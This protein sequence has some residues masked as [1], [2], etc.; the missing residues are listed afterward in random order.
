MRPLTKKLI[1]DLLRLWPQVTAI[2]L[3]M[4]AGVATLILAAGAYASLHETRAAYYQRNRFG[5]IFASVTRA[6]KRLV[7]QIE[8]IPGV[9]TVDSRIVKLALLDIVGMREPA[10]ARLISLPD[11]GQQVLNRV[12]LRA[13]RFPLAGA[14]D[15][16]VVNESFARAHGFGIGSRFAVL[17][18]GAKRRLRIVGIGL[19]PEYIY[20]LGPGELMPDDRRFGVVFLSESVLAA[21]YDLNGAFSDVSV[22]LL[23]DASRA[24]VIEALDR[25]LKPHGGQGA[26]SRKDQLSHAFIDSELKQ[27]QAMARVLPPIFLLVATFLVNMTLS[28]L[29]A[30]ERAEIGLLKAIGYS[31]VAVGAHYLKFVLAIAFFGIVIGAVAGTLLGI[32]L[33]RLYADFFRFPFLIF[34]K[35][36][37][38]YV[39]AAAITFAASFLGALKAVSEVVDLP[40]AVAMAPP[41]PPRYRR[42]FGAGLFRRLALSRIAMMAFRHVAHRPGRTASSVFGISLSVAILV[43]SLWMIPSIE[44]MIDVTFFQTERQDVSI[45]FAEKRRLAALFEARRLPGVL[46]A[47]PYRRVPVRIRKGHVERRIAI[48]GKPETVDLNRVLNAAFQ[49]I[50]PPARGLAV[51]DML[52]DV[53]KVERGDWVE[54]DVLE[55]RR[56]T[57]RITVAEIVTGFLGIS[58]FIELSALNRLLREGAM[59]SGVHIVYDRA[60]ENAFFAAVKDNPATGFV[61]LQKSSLRQFRK[62]LAE[63]INIMITVYLAFAVIIAFGVVYN[64]AR[65]SL[66]E[67]GRELA[68]LRVLGFTKAEVSRVLLIELAFTTLAAQPF[69]WVIGHGLAYAT[70][71]GFE[72]E[73]YRIPFVIGPPVYAISSLVVLAAAGISALAVR[74]RIDRLDLIAVLKTRE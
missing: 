43:A 45:S 8:K 41:A 15:E 20:A 63:N 74:Q 37:S 10:T 33:T 44:F 14:S 68:S 12:Y 61:S 25:L 11:T 60:E 1:R 18:N 55:G 53:L 58:A 27:L 62:T 51:S 36:P 47:E 59:I 66:S 35:D 6:P 46:A 71:K 3:V 49:P 19:S 56:R 48:V 4:A 13:G 72:S 54:I 39:I 9:A 32:G 67:R 69:G 22:T 52:A 31:D 26:Y 57:F 21:A 70:V 5:E 7:E 17:L 38:L 24:R 23:R 73:L 42:R 64:S 16:A 40:P 50:R 29:V 34:R 28:R 2:A 30:L 65:I